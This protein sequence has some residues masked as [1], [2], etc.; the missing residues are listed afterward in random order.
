MT[1]NVLTN[2]T[3]DF[4]PASV[5]IVA[6][7]GARVTTLAVPGQGTWTVNPTTGALTF[8][9]EPGLKSKPA[10]WIRSVTD[11]TGDTVDATVTV[12]YVPAAVD[13][14][15]TGNTIG[16]PVTVNVLAND[17]GDF[18]PASVRIVGAWVE[19]GA[20]PWLCPGRAPGR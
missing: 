7:G 6:P 12:T 4:N 5:R 1:V 9:P 2:D 19:L 8:T 10:P 15:D 16:D 17:T 11:T 13:D 14:S 3:G 20:R 18:D